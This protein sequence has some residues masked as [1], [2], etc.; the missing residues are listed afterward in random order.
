[1]GF[2]KQRSHSLT[3]AAKLDAMDGV[4]FEQFVAQLFRS[5]GTWSSSPKLPETTASILSCISTAR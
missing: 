2:E 5:K 1:L 3:L 4:S